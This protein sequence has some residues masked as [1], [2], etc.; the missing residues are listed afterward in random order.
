MIAAIPLRGFDSAKTRLAEELSPGDRAAVAAAVAGRV[1]RACLAAGWHVVVVSSAPD[2]IAWCDGHH[3]D[4]LA[5]PGGGLNG[6]AAAGAAAAPGP[7]MVIHGDLPL[8][9][10]ADLEGVAEAIREGAVVL[11]PSRDGGTNVI[12]AA[13]PFRFSYG[14]GSFARHLAAAAPR[15]PVTLIRAGLAVE[16]DT[17]ADLRATLRHPEGRWLT[18]FLS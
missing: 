15:P 6:A 5:D 10:A 1:A 17:P 18:E 2:V 14:P 13:S 12:A 16:L 7:W 8:V 9:A 3:L 11:A 4:R